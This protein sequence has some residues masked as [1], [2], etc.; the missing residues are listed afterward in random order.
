MEYMVLKKALPVLALL[1]L[2]G[3][4]QEASSIDPGVDNSELEAL[5]T[6]FLAVALEHGQDLSQRL[7]LVGFGTVRGGSGQAAA[8]CEKEAIP[9]VVFDTARWTELTNPQK[10]ALMFHELGHCVLNRPHTTELQSTNGC[11]SSVMTATLPLV[12]CL[13]KNEDVYDAE[14]FS[15]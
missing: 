13:E 4:G 2:V 12:S 14:L 3:C 6:E 11:P 9:T 8:V 15:L 10:R 7:V 1:L 5:K